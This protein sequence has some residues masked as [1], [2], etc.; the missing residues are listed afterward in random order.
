M[1]KRILELANHADNY[2]KQTVHYY[3]GQFDGLTWEEKIKQSRDTKFAKM[4]VRECI[5]VCQ[6]QATYDPIVLPYKPSEQFASAI[7]KHF[8]V[9]Q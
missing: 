2:A 1:N 7:K 4:I 3:M 9:E 5:E 6:G 8:G